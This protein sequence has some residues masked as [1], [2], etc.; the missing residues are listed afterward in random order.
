MK[1]T[2]KATCAEATPQP[3][4]ITKRERDRCIHLVGRYLTGEIKT[5]WELR[6]LIE[7]GSEA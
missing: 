3:W 1:K 6:D 7:S 4:E 2:E 5:Q